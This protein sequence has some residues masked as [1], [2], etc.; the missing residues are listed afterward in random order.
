MLTINSSTSKKTLFEMLE[1]AIDE[2][3]DLE[4]IIDSLPAFMST[5]IALTIFSYQI[6]R[7]PRQII[8]RC[9]DK[10]TV[11]LLQAV[12]FTA[13]RKLTI[14]PVLATAVDLETSPGYSEPVE[15]SDRG[16]KLTNSANPVAPDPATSVNKSLEVRSFEVKKTKIENPLVISLKPKQTQIAKSSAVLGTLRQ[17]FQVGQLKMTTEEAASSHVFSFNSWQQS[18]KPR[19]RLTPEN[20]TATHHYQPSALLDPGLGST[21]EQDLDQWLR[22]VQITKSAIDSLRFRNTQED[23]LVSRELLKNRATKKHQ[24][25]ARLFQLVTGAVL[26]TSAIILFLL[27]FPTT[28]YTVELEKPLIEQSAE[29]SFR[30][31]EFNQKSVILSTKSTIETTGSKEIETANATGKAILLNTSGKDLNLTNGG[32]YLVADGKKYKHEYDPNQ[33][34]IITIPAGNH[35]NGPTVEIRIRAVE[36]GPAANLP[37]NTRFSIINLKEQNVGNALFG[38]STTPIQNKELSGE[39]V[40]TQS[41]FDL[42]K[43]LNEG[44]IAQELGKEIVAVQAADVFTNAE[45][46]S[47]NSQNL[48]YDARVGEVKPK[49][50]LVTESVFTVYYLPK[51]TIERKLKSQ[52]TKIDDLVEVLIKKQHG[53]FEKSD[54]LINLDVFYSYRESLELDKGSISRTL[55][56]QKSLD[57]AEQKLRE[58][59]PQIKRIDKR[60][61]GLFLPM[62]NPKIDID[63]VE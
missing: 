48:E 50:S 16:E 37:E 32:F 59:Y 4:I 51:E 11:D 33:S 29:I 8:W 43:T 7:Y 2:K 9:Q 14:Q 46:Y 52:N 19:E 34:R 26:T 22:K 63:I 21:K 61:T 54:N 57:E 62:I 31:S 27:I 42:L 1:N 17:R 47:Q 13:V 23:D 3:G 28:V 25:L 58:Q 44:K 45:W 36:P 18:L 10:E 41:D 20:I 53:S 60:E 24:N 15:E 55:A 40:A 5:R 12:G 49:I 6:D 30:V 35:L 39:K 38:I 56:S